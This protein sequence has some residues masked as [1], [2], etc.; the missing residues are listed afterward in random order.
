[1]GDIQF[2]SGLEIERVESGYQ[3]RRVGRNGWS[4][5]LHKITKG[6]NENMRNERYLTEITRSGEWSG[7]IVRGCD[8]RALI[9][10]IASWNQNGWGKKITHLVH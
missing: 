7:W 5:G 4:H 10:L 6:G 2:K 9:V 1:M 8:Q 3:E